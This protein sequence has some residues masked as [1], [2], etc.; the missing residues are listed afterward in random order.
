MKNKNLKKSKTALFVVL[1]ILVGMTNVFAQVEQDATQTLQKYNGT[2]KMIGFW[3]Y[4]DNAIQSEEKEGVAQYE[5]KEASDG[6]RLFHGKFYFARNENVLSYLIENVTLSENSY[7]STDN[8]QK[9]I[10]S[11]LYLAPF[12]IGKFDND[13]QVGKWVWAFFSNDGEKFVYKE[14]NFDNYGHGEPNG[15]VVQLHYVM[16]VPKFFYT[17]YLDIY[18]VR[19]PRGYLIADYENGYLDE[20]E[21]KLGWGEGSNESYRYSKDQRLEWWHPDHVMLKGRF[22][23]RGP[24]GKWSV[25]GDYFNENTVLEYNE[26][27]VCIANYWIDKSTGDKKRPLKVSENP[28]YLLDDARNT[29]RKVFYKS[30]FR[31][32]PK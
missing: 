13:R 23:N 8:I 14:I 27:G 19:S 25:S 20:L 3:C 22:N 2:F 4:S 16:D 31:S 11:I 21:Y 9:N 10:E 6:T 30:I 28:A 7:F 18:S 32:T 1:L 15:A 17:D 5:Y 29:L 12:A 24:V 26:N